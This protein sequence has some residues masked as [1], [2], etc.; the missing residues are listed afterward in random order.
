MV[1]ELLLF[2]FY[3]V[4]DHVLLLT[5]VSVGHQHRLCRVLRVVEFTATVLE[6]G[7]HCGCQ[8]IKELRGDCAVERITESHLDLVPYKTSIFVEL[9]DFPKAVKFIENTCFSAYTQDLAWLDVGDF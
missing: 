1:W 9:F 4:V 3:I 6:A 2:V 5:L 8:E 7:V